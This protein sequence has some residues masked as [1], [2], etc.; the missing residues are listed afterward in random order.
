[1]EGLNRYQ[2]LETS[3]KTKSSGL[4][5]SGH[6]NSSNCIT[7]S[8]TI[9][10]LKL[11]ILTCYYKIDRRNLLDNDRRDQKNILAYANL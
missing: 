11:K 4:L 6:V 9:M 3:T 7:Q 1:M 8:N 2:L 5:P 10:I